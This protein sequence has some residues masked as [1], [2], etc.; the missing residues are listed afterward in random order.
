MNFGEIEE[1]LELHAPEVLGRAVA[2]DDLGAD[3]NPQGFAG[4]HWR[5]RDAGS[6]GAARTSI[7]PVT[8]A[9]YKG[10][11]AFPKS[12][13]HFFAGADGGH[14]TLATISSTA[15]TMDFCSAIGGSGVVS[16]PMRGIPMVLI[17]A[18][19]VSRSSSP[20]MA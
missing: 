10:R 8:A 20:F 12:H 11:S 14:Q 2:S 7:W 17:V 13:K 9:V 1:F 5:L 16:C 4:C 19:A 3:D 6:K 18:P 15:A